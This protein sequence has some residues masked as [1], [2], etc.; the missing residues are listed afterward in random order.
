MQKV[1]L[2]VVSIYLLVCLVVY[3]TQDYILFQRGALA[4]DYQYEIDGDYQELTL[5][6]D[7]LHHAVH[8]KKADPDGIIVYFHGNRDSLKRWIRLT[9]NLNR[10]NYDLL[11]LEYPEYGKSK[12]KLSQ[13]EIE[14]LAQSGYEYANQFFDSDQIVI[15]GRSIGTGPAS[16]LASNKP[17]RAVVLETPYYSLSDLLTRYLFLLPRN[18]LINYQFDN[19]ANLLNLGV[20]IIL[21]HGTADQIIPIGMA[22]RLAEALGEKANYVVIKGGRHHNLSDYEEYWDTLDTIFLN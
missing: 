22:D 13:H 3:F 21:L 15:F 17:S 20:P 10:Y 5:G 7:Q 6:E 19:H 18:W 4:N 16:L 8:I 2:I 11:L 9:R 1:F 14:N 12:A